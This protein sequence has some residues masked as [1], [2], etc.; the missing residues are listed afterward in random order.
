ME[1][2]RTKKANTHRQKEDVKLILV[3]A[4]MGK[5][6]KK[7]YMKEFTSTTHHYFTLE[8]TKAK[9]SMGKTQ[10]WKLRAERLEHLV[11]KPGQEVSGMVL[12]ARWIKN[13][14]Q[15]RHW[16]SEAPGQRHES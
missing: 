7:E 4:R 2:R 3:R 8:E 15:R 13:P 1:E 5:K 14:H 12:W 6:K 9:G 10:A 16:R 11:K